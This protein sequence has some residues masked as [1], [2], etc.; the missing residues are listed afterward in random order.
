MFARSFWQYRPLR[1]H[2]T[3]AHYLW[4]TAYYSLTQR[5]G[6]HARAR[7]I[8]NVVQHVVVVVMEVGL[9]RAD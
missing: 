6:G 2:V 8:S 4:V 5:D 1:S 7:I 3:V 9:R